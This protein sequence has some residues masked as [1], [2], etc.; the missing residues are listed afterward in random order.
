MKTYHTQVSLEIWVGMGLM[1]FIIYTVKSIDKRSK[2]LKTFSPGPA[3][4]H[5]EQLYLEPRSDE[6]SAWLCI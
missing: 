3:H 1:V 5:R 4:G 2:A 6:T